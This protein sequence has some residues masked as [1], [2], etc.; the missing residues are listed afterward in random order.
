[1][2]ALRNSRTPLADLQVA[3]SNLNR[4]FDEAFRGFP[5]LNAE[6]PVVGTW[7]PPVDVVESAN[8]LRIVAEMPGVRPEDIKISMEN[9]VLML[10]GEKQQVA[11][12]EENGERV[13]RFERTYGAFERS[14]MV[15]SS[16]DGERIQARSEHGI[17]TLTLPKAEK[18][19]PRQI[20]VQVQA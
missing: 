18:A 9:N 6:T 15:P 10:R 13:H 3:S 2:F 19:K 5:S 4:L 1:M 20:T 14:F 7:L 17:L 8:E 12:S 16:V 11:A